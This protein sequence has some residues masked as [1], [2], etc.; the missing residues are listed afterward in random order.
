MNG[1]YKPSKAFCHSDTSLS[2]HQLFQGKQLKVHEV[3]FSVDVKS[4]TLHGQGIA[5][6]PL[7]C[8]WHVAKKKRASGYRAGGRIAQR[9]TLIRSHGRKALSPLPGMI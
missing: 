9:D 1:S 4:T 6:L 7:S 2:S 3:S 5:L 8:A